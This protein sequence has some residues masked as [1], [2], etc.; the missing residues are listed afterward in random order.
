MKNQPHK[1]LISCME[2]ISVWKCANILTLIELIIANMEGDCVLS[3]MCCCNVARASMCQRH[4]A[5]LCLL[6]KMADQHI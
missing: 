3:S 4:I 5:W 2:L 6:K 1:S